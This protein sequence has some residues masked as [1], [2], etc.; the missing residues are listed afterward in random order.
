MAKKIKTFTVDENVY[1]SVVKLFKKS[2]AEVSVSLFINNCLEELLVLLQEVDREI[3]NA[4]EYTVP[5]SFIIKS[6][7]DRNNILGIGQD[8]P[9]D[10]RM[11]ILLQFWQEEYESKQKKIPYQLY[12]HIAGNSVYML[13]PDKKYLINKITG[14][15]YIPVGEN[16]LVRIGEGKP[17]RKGMKK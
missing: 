14:E 6:I 4:P 3:K 10:I 11:D 7:I 16:R 2:G 8:I 1:N 13:S 5:L 17:R 9:E 15:S 12:K